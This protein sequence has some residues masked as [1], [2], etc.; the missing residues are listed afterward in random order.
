LFHSQLAGG[1]WGH[2]IAGISGGRLFRKTSFLQDSL[3]Q[4]VFPNFVNIYERPHILGGLAS[5]SFDN[6]GVATYDKDIVKDG[7][8]NSYILS[9]YS[10]R[11]LGMQSTGNAGGIHNVFINNTGEDFQALLKK[12]GRGLVVTEL[13]G[14]GVN[15]V[16]GDYSRGVAGFWVEHGEIQFPVHE[17]TIASNLAQ[18]FKQIVAVGTDVDKRGS[19]Q[20]GSILI[21]EMMLAGV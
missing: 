19:I 21:E 2:F 18:M 4:Q 11:K 6:D 20:S 14:Q 8:V 17:V 5:S 16:T 15:L 7:T 12:M 1:I 10:A 3:G 13:M 9:A